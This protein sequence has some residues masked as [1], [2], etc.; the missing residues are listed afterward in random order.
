MYMVDDTI[1]W[2]Q[3]MHT[4]TLL[5]WLE[6]TLIIVINYIYSTQL[7]QHIYAHV[8]SIFLN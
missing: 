3:T 2:L 4:S 5:K 7:T 6:I 1:I 8:N